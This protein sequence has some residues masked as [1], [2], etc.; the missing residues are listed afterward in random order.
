MQKRSLDFETRSACNLLTDG[1]Y[2]YAMDPTTEVICCS[3]MMPDGSVRSWWPERIAHAIDEKSQY[4]PY[5]WPRRYPDRKYQAW[6]SQ[7]DRLIWQYVAEND[8]GFPQTEIHDWICTAALSRG[9]GLP[10]ALA[11]AARALNLDAQ[12][13][14]RGKELIQLLSI[15][16]GGT[17]NHPT[18]NEDPKLLREMIAYCE[19]DVRTEDAMAQTM[20]PFLDHELD[21]FWASE[22]INDRGVA[23]DI[24]FARKAVTYS[25]MEMSVLEQKLQDATHDKIETPKQYQKIKMWLLNGFAAYE[26]LDEKGLRYVYEKNVPSGLDYE[27][28]D[29]DPEGAD[30]F[31]ALRINEEAARQMTVYKQGARKMSLDK[32]VRNNLIELYDEDPRIL[33]RKSTRLNSSHTDISR[34]PSSA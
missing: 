4:L 11:D 20:R 30:D 23:L 34:M 24:P 7:F 31:I 6:N 16:N 3:W 18:F 21:E 12:K 22:V 19:Q 2:R 33:D 32:N 9:N 29:D 5:A 13:D 10:G 8:Y 15:P 17:R 25:E 26:D 27:L 28:I 1:A 14:Q